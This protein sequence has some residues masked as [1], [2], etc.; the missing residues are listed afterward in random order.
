ML[1]EGG[2]CGAPFRSVI[3]VS[4]DCDISAGCCTASMSTRGACSSAAGGT[5][6]AASAMA[7]SASASGAR[8]R[9][10]GAFAMVW[11]VAG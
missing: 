5:D 9:A 11:G 3:G 2:K 7:V 4:S 1:L 8:T 10:V 6:T